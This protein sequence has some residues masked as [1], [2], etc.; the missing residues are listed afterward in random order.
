M[1]AEREQGAGGKRQISVLDTVVCMV[2]MLHSLLEYVFHIK[3]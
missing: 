1:I 2:F 3:K